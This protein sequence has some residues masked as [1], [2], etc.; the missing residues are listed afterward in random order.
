MSANNVIAERLV[1]LVGLMAFVRRLPV[2]VGGL[3]R[4]L[5]GGRVRALASVGGTIVCAMLTTRD[6]AAATEPGTESPAKDDAEL[7]SNLS[8]DELLNVRVTSVYS[9][10]KHEQK[11][12]QAPAAVSIITADD[13][14][15]FGYRN[16]AEALRSVRGFYAANDRNYSYLGIRGFNRPGDYNTRV[17]LM[18]DGHRMN[19]N[20]YDSAQIGA[21]DFLDVDLIDRVEV[22]RGP[23]SSIYGNNA[24]LG[25]INVIT[26]RGRHFGG[27]EASGAYGT[28]DTYT[29]RLTYGN[30]FDSGVDLLL[31]GTLYGSAGDRRLYYS[32]FDNAENNF[33]VAEDSDEDYS[34][35]FF[36]SLGWRDLT[37][38]GGYSWREK[39]IPTASFGTIFND[40]HEVVTDVRAFADLKY[41]RQ[42]AGE[43]EFMGRTFYDRY[44][45]YGNYPF[46]TTEFGGPPRLINKDV[47]QGDWIGIEA[48][49]AKTLAERYRLMVGTDYRENIGQFQYNFDD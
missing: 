28:F 6:L 44:E 40:G 14:K 7:L 19:D 37:L 45:Y 1:C 39:N 36:G 20:I 30:S 46:D 21:E 12:A 11:I 15:K 13:F 24:F 41:E 22:I 10:S 29:G 17:L 27:L 25:V 47:S 42:F 3:S 18:V 49:V 34:R 9:A 16:L 26:K 48:Q 43:I 4:W 33:G 32:E 38:S 5:R 31:S 35:K 23:S 2:L 8:M